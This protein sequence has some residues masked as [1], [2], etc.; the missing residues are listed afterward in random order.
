M[1]IIKGTEGYWC[2][3]CGILTDKPR[4]PKC[5]RRYEIIAQTIEKKDK[6]D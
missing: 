1:K 4:C 3:V 2:N 5:K 6:Y